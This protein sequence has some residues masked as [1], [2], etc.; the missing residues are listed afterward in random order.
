MQPQQY[1]HKGAVLVS[2]RLGDETSSSMVPATGKVFG[3]VWYESHIEVPLEQLHRTYTG[4]SYEKKYLVFGSRALQLWGYGKEAY[5]HS[6]AVANRKTLSF[7]KWTMPIGWLNERIYEVNDEKAILDSR[8][9]ESLGVKRAADKLLQAAGEGSRLSEAKVIKSKVENG[10]QIIT[11]LIEIEED[12]SEE[13]PVVE[14]PPAPSAP[15]GE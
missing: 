9:A 7:R 12:I 2:G 8:S 1:V 6:A 10:K 13:L 4:N 14:L 11:A 3:L 15:P 5:P